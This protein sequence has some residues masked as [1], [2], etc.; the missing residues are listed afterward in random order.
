MTVETLGNLGLEA[1]RRRLRKGTL[2]VRIGPFV[3]CV[4]SGIA[5]FADWLTQLYCDYEVEPPAGFSDLHVH[6]DPPRS[7]RRWWRPQVQ[8]ALDHDRPFKPLPRSQACPF[9]EWGLN[10]CVA[11]R[12]QQYLVVHAAVVE[13]DGRAVV[14]PGV[15]GVGKSTLCAG[16]VAR[17]WRLFSDELA[18][19][20]PGEGRIDPFPRPVGLKDASI[21]IIRAFAPHMT[22]GPPCHDTAK[23]TVAHLRPPPDSVNRADEG[24]M[25]AALIFPRYEAGTEVEISRR[26]A[27]ALRSARGVP[28]DG[29]ALRQSRCRLRGVR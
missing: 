18:L 2:R 17:G 9:F 21:G 16:L 10:W 4:R 7:L 27:P 23:G 13:R 26:E 12:A 29:T 25:P 6:I 3:V 15:P 22:I 11:Q 24:A 1:A 19:I 20:R 8:F 14:M 28:A 5:E